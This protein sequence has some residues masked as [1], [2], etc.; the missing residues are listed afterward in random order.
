MEMDINQI[1]KQINT[2]FYNAILKYGW[3][4]F[5]HEILAENLT[6]E[7]ASR[8]TGFP[9]HHINNCCNDKLDQYLGYVFNYE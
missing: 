1:K 5:K 6:K 9:Y 8:Q 3:G 2:V 4:T 7:E